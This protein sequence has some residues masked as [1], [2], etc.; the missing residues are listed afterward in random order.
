[1]LSLAAAFAEV[2]RKRKKR[3]KKKNG[4]FCPLNFWLIVIRRFVDIYT[5][6]EEEEESI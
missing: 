5:H 4:C 6:D 3:K 1:M 2:E